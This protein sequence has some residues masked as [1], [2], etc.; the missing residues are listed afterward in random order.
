MLKPLEEKGLKHLVLK[1]QRDN[2]FTAFVTNLT[3][4]TQFLMPQKLV[5]PKQFALVAEAFVHSPKKDG[6]V[7]GDKYLEILMNKVVPQLQQQ[8]NSHY[9]YFQQD[10]APPHY[11]RT[12]REYLDETFPTKWIGRRGPID[13]P[14]RSPDLPQWISFSFGVY[15]RTKFIVESH[16]VSVI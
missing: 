15:S 9:L 13:W 2:L 11:S 7:T 8:P 14:A 6:I 4:L 1:P 10:W 3:P 12:V 16:E 5:D